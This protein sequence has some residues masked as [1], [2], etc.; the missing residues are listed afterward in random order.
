MFGKLSSIIRNF[1]GLQAPLGAGV[2]APASHPG[3]N[4]LEA[5]VMGRLRRESVPE[6]EEHLLTCHGCRLRIEELESFLLTFREAA[7]GMEMRPVRAGNKTWNHR[8]LAWGL[9]MSA[10]VMVA[11]VTTR[12]S[13][14][15]PAPPPALVLHPF[16]GTETPTHIQSGTNFRLVLDAPLASST[17]SYQVQFV[18]GG[19]HPF[20]TAKV[21]AQGDRLTLE[22]D[23]LTRGRYWVRVYGNSMDTAPLM[24]YRLQVE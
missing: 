12:H 21:E 11:V 15:S 13:G 8:S 9:A 10:A 6:L 1:L 24:E 7:D 22:C 17:H 5:Y 2:T 19:G 16:R 23:R 4:L 3:D 18:D 20:R 14:V